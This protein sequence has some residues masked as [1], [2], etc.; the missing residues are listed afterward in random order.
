MSNKK[1]KAIRWIIGIIIVLIAIRLALPYGIKWYLNNRVLNNLETYEGRVEDVDL[2]LIRGAYAI[3]DLVISKRE[4]ELEEPFIDIPRTD[5][6]VQWSALFD[7]EIVGE[8]VCTGAII[9]F[10][11]GEEEAT[12]Q[13]GAEEDW[14]QVVKDLIPIKINRFVIKNGEIALTNVWATPSTDLP[15]D[16]FN[17]EILN[18]QNTLEEDADA[19][20]SKITASG[21]APDYG[22]QLHFD[23]DAMLLKTFPDFDYEMRFEGVNLKNLNPIMEHYTDM[24]FEKGR[25]SIYSEMAMKDQQFEGY[26]KPL[27]ED[28]RIFN[29]KEDDRSLGQWFKEFFGEGIQEV[30]ENQPRQQFATKVPMSGTVEDVKTALWPT[31]I[32]TLRNAYFN[33]FKYEL[34]K[35]V[36]FED[37]ENS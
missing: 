1:R 25:I 4:A 23:A 3:D 30:L 27:I 8:V 15:L 29:W 17:L 21:I 33:A 37:L 5:L 6:S 18:I 10:A 32:N 20:P 14:T 11:F 16:S 24:D 22:G 7:G 9:N 12:S 2:M 34:D 36:Q 19:L 13:T 31:L 35:S 28:M 26:V